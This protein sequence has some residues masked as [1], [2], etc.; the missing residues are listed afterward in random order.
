M[1]AGVQD[2]PRELSKGKQNAQGNNNPRPK[3]SRQRKAQPKQD[4]SGPAPNI[5]LLEVRT[6]VGPEMLSR[7]EGEAGRPYVHWK[8]HLSIA[9]KCDDCGELIHFRVDYLCDTDAH[10]GKLSRCL[11]DHKESRGHTDAMKSQKATF[12]ESL[13]RAAESEEPAP[14]ERRRALVSRRRKA[15]PG[16]VQASFSRLGSGPRSTS[17]S[18]AL[19]TDAGRSFIGG[20]VAGDTPAALPQALPTT[21]GNYTMDLP[22]QPSQCDAGRCIDIVSLR[23]RVL[24]NPP[25]GLGTSAVVYASARRKPRDGV[26]V[27]DEQ[28]ESASYLRKGPLLALRAEAC[29]LVGISVLEPKA[30]A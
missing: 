30:S 10:A 9:Y 27:L 25:L 6:S 24:Y 5:P 18:S 19:L 21:D 15:P 26:Y 3:P 7:A 16:S 11:R 20:G 4:K 28:I 8:P 12:A 23:G 29:K 13:S 2:M 14:V 17:G 1:T 22:G